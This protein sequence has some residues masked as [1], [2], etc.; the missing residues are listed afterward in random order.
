MKFI[1]LIDDVESNDH[2]M[3]FDISPE[4]E[5]YFTKDL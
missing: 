3:V 1:L 4:R 5:Q 2:F